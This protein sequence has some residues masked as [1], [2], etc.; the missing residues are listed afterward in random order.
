M[1]RVSVG[2]IIHGG[3]RLLPPVPCGDAV[4]HQHQPYFVTHIVTSKSRQAARACHEPRECSWSETGTGA[5]RAS[6]GM[7]E[8]NGRFSW[9]VGA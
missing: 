4:I 5:E 7:M 3:G 8:E 1:L 2:L 6:L 9:A